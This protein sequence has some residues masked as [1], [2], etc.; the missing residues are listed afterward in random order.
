MARN[1]RTA[2]QA[3]PKAYTVQSPVEHDGVR[4]EPGEPIELSEDQAKPLI[5]A[6][7]I[8]PAA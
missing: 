5:D 6:G 4:Y 8:K 3:S 1:S 7:A 2:D